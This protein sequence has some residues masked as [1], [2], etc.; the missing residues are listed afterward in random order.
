MSSSRPN[1]R[2]PNNMYDPYSD[3]DDDVMDLHMVCQLTR[4]IPTRQPQRNCPYTSTSQVHG[5]VGVQNVHGNED[6]VPAMQQQNHVN[7]SR[8]QLVQMGQWRDEVAASMW[9]AYNNRA[10]LLMATN[11]SSPRTPSKYRGS[12]VTATQPQPVHKCQFDS[13]NTKLF[14]QLIIA[15]MEGGTPPQ[16]GYDTI[17]ENV[18]DSSLFEDAPPQSAVDGS[19]NPKRRKR[20][21]PG[22]NTMGDCL[23]R[24]MS[25]TRLEPSG[26]LF[27]FA[28]GIMDSPD[29]RD[30]IM[31]L[32]QN[33]IINWLTE[34]RACTPANVGRDREGGTRLF[35]SGGAVDLD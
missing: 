17:G 33:Y 32:S 19:A 27:S 5:E 25:M 34:K 13:D 7:M 20:A 16:P 23:A 24:L 31:A 29:N 30:I 10:T 11:R 9:E 26:K 35:E 3:D 8:E 28:C 4:D 14:L 21:M 22:D 18:V 12:A 6:G 2:Q 1:G 15:E